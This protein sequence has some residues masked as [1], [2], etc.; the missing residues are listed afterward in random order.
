MKNLKRI[1]TIILALALALSPTIP[2]FAAQA[3]DAEGNI[4]RARETFEF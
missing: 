3:V 2:G 4:R 1:S